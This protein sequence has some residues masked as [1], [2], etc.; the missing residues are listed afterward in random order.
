MLEDVTPRCS[1]KG[2]RDGVLS[3]R[4]MTIAMRFASCR[5]TRWCTDLA[6]TLR[7]L[8]EQ[9]GSHNFVILEVNDEKNY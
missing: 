5:A 8:T 9:R 2:K 7:C 6:N 3:R 1:A 4:T